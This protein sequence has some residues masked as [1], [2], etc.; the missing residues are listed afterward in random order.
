MKIPIE[1]RRTEDGFSF[2][3][4]FI[5]MLILSGGLLAL[6]SAFAQGM[7]IA[8]TSHYHQIAKAKA[9]EAIESVFTSRDTHTIAWA[10]I[11]N[12]S[13]GGVFLDDPQPIRTAGPDGLVNTADDSVAE[14]EILPGPDGELGTDDDAVVSLN[15]FS[16]EIVITDIN[17]N[18]REIQVI[19]RYQIGPLSRRY[20]LVTQISAFA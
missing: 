13:H 6:A 12:E 2:V 15:S 3:E 1:R 7:I 18:L 16:R 19:I 5:A 11:R 20:E 10:S 9:T 17:P 4:V 14:N 8:S